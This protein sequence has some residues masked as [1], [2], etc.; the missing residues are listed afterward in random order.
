MK[1]KF[2]LSQIEQLNSELVF[3]LKEK[4]KFS[5]KW[6]IKLLIEQIEKP[7]NNFKELQND[8]FKKYGVEE[9]GKITLLNENIEIATKELKELSEKT[10]N[11]EGYLKMKDLKDLKSEN[12]YYLIF[13]LIKHD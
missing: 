4:L 5:V 1:K 12:P 6:E 9:N 3:L 11:L 7:L 8:L 13:N 10:F 2:K